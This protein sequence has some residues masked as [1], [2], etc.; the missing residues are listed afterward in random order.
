MQNGGIFSWRR[1]RQPKA[2]KLSAQGRAKAEAYGQKRLREKAAKRFFMRMKRT[3]SET[4]SSSI[5]LGDRVV[6]V[7]FEENE[8]VH[9]VKVQAE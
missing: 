6:Y 8:T 9:T 3:S 1:E 4:E 5:Y 7:F 2:P